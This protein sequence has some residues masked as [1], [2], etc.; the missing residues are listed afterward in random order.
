M[1]GLT[2]RIN[3]DD[4]RPQSILD[5]LSKGGIVGNCEAKR[6]L[7]ESCHAYIRLYSK[8]REIGCNTAAIEAILRDIQ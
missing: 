3:R 4:F 7:E 2:K 5:S 8:L 6:L 1:R